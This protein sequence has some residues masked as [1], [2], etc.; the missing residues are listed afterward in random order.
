MVDSARPVVVF[1]MAALLLAIAVSGRADEE[2][3]L[4]AVQDQMRA[5]QQRL[6]KQSAEQSRA[7]QDLKRVET[8]I[9]KTSNRLAELTAERQQL[10]ERQGQLVDE[11]EASSQR[12]AEQRARLSR[13]LRMSYMSGRRENL[14]VLLNQ[15]SPADLGRMMVYYDYLNRARSTRIDAVR[16][17]LIKLKALDDENAR[18]LMDLAGLE[19]RQQRSLA[20]LTNVRVERRALLDDLA[21]EI[22]RGGSELQ[23]LKEQEQSLQQLV[24]ELREFLKEFPQDS[25][26]RFSDVRGQLAWPVKGTLL[27]DFG[28]PKAGSLTWNGVLVAARQG[29]P[30]RALYHGRVVFAEWLAGMGMLVVIDHGQG[31]MSLYGHNEALLAEAGD[32]VQPGQR[33]ALVGDSGGMPESALYFE[34]RRGGVPENPRAWIGR[35]LAAR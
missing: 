26:R 29:D 30:V 31:Y 33:I 13:Q 27:R 2:A 22:R 10:A 23:R 18:L 1:L 17:E 8:E 3:E 24:Q 7:S 20:E 11:Q 25:E 21:L 15:D 4:K 16:G 12:L 9:G 6:S 28:Q 35:R 14:K 5:L 32:W 19:E 34:I